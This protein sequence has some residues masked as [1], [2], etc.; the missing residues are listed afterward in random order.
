LDVRLYLSCLAS[1]RP[2]F[3]FRSRPPSNP[4][5]AGAEKD[6]TNG[7]LLDRFFGIA[8][9]YGDWTSWGSGRA[10]LRCSR[11]RRPP[12]FSTPLWSNK[13]AFEVDQAPTSPQDGLDS[14]WPCA[15]RGVGNGPEP[16]FWQVE[17]DLFPIRRS[18]SKKPVQLVW[19]FPAPAESHTD[20]ARAR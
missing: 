16:S 2:V 15:A 8:S 3:R 18:D 5:R 17:S 11:G 4:V 9:P 6:Q 19:S 14:E 12:P 7:P 13:V 1:V 20:S 10:V